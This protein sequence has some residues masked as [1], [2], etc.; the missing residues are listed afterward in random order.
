[1]KLGF[2]TAPV[3]ARCSAVELID[4]DIVPGSEAGFG[5]APGSL[6]LLHGWGEDKSS[7]RNLGER[8][9]PTGAEAI[10]PSMRGHGA[11]PQ[12]VWGCAPWELAVDV[13]RIGDRLPVPVH[14]V[15]YSYGAL[16]AALATIVLGPE[17]VGSLVLLDQSFER[18]DEFVELVDLEDSFLQW[19]FDHRHVLDAITALG[20]PMLIVVADH[21]T[22]VG[23]AER[24]RLQR[25]EGALCRYV[26]LDVDHAGLVSEV[27]PV[28]SVCRDFYRWLE[29]RRG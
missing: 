27:D 9:C 25:R 28:A 20:V 2:E 22:V 21:S 18:N 14:V 5:G 17:R 16:I 23:Q 3:L 26:C 12:G 13:Q 8:L 1:M 19:H 10:Y 29:G 4:F 15:G 7:L 6:L 11:S 24:E